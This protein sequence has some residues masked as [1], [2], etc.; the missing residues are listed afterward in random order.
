VSGYPAV[1]SLLERG[2]PEIRLTALAPPIAE[3]QGELLRVLSLGDVERLS[4]KSDLEAAYR[5]FAEAIVR[6]NAQLPLERSVHKVELN[7]F[8]PAIN[9]DSREGIVAQLFSAKHLREITLPRAEWLLRDFPLSSASIECSAPPERI[10]ESWKSLESLRS[11]ESLTF[12]HATSDRLI[13]GKK[14]DLEH[15]IDLLG[16]VLTRNKQ[17]RLLPTT[18]AGLAFTSTMT[19]VVIEPLAEYLGEVFGGTETG[20]ALA[21]VNVATLA[22]AN[23]GHDKAM[24]TYQSNLLK[25]L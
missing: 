10:L 1:L 23:K 24:Q 19:G 20:R 25:L 6:A 7:T 5:W 17:L 18:E 2:V 8:A 4:L 13:H 15:T 14:K 11:L 3:A 16:A 12:I 9:Y 22:G 21:E